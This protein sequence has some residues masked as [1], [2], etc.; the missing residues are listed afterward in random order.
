[1]AVPARPVS[2]NVVDSAWGQVAH[3]TA[4][5]MDLQ[6]GV[7][8]MP[9]AVAGNASMTVTFPRPFASPPVVTV[10]GPGGSSFFM[11]QVGAITATTVVLLVRDIRDAQGGTGVTTLQ[12]MAY[13][14]RA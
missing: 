1:M 7:A 10:G 2:G 6:A 5:A 14:P 8:N 3:D 12:W 11:C 4:V 9:S 13:G